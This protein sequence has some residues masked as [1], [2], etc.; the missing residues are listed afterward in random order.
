MYTKS[1]YC[2]NSGLY[3]VGQVEILTTVLKIVLFKIVDNFT[4][5][6]QLL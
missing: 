4:L 6:L 3:H 5:D 1:F 2:R